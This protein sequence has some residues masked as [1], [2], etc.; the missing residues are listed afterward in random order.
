MIRDLKERR[1]DIMADMAVDMIT[2][3]SM[4]KKN[5]D[6]GKLSIINELLDEDFYEDLIDS[7]IANEGTHE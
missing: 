5:F 3:E 4:H 6:L 1:K 7:L 2:E